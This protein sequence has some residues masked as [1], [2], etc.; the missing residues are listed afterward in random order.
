MKT[1]GCILDFSNKCC[2]WKN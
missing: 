2:F 1:L